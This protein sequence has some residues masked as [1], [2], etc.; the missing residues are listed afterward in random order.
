[1]RIAFRCDP[2]LI[3]TLPRPTPARQGLPTW[4]REM[5]ATAFSTTHAQDVRTVKQCPPFIDAMAHGFLI[6]LPCDVTVR[7]GVFSWDWDLP[8]LSV[9]AHPRS[10]L[11]FHVP[12][13]VTGTPFHESARSIVKFNCFWTI[14]LEPGYSLFAT[15]PVNRADLPFRLLTGMIDADRFHDV[16]ILFP[17][18]WTEPDFEGVLRAGTPIA[19]CFPVFREPLSLAYESLS[20]EG[21][22][23]YDSTAGALLS[24]PGVY[25]RRYRARTRLSGK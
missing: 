13:Q 2:A 20:V 8:A 24:K 11:S 10:P 22:E 12:A 23:R 1:M 18:I 21:C 25:R 3:E 9:S 17:A 14:E 15:H 19:Q 6:P 4:V 16:G 5:P 7:Q